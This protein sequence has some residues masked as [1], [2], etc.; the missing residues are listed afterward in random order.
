MVWKGS[1]GQAWE[2]C[3][4]WESSVSGRGSRQ[5]LLWVEEG[6]QGGAEQEPAESRSGN[7]VSLGTSV[8]THEGSLSLF[9]ASYVRL[10]SRQ[11]SVIP[12]PSSAALFQLDLIT[13][14]PICS[15]FTAPSLL[16][17]P[18]PFSK[19]FMCLNKVYLSSSV[20]GFQ[21]SSFSI[22]GSY[23]LKEPPLPC[24]IHSCHVALPGSWSHTFYLLIRKKN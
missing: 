2:A 12:C 8:L 17:L 20:P 19:S 13:L 1:R 21:L 3:G 9:A 15:L 23:S 18:F 22:C 10:C 7:S 16:L 5:W 14:A 11:A 24:S 4:G 6:E